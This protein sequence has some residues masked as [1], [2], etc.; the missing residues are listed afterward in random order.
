QLTCFLH[1]IPLITPPLETTGLSYDAGSRYAAFDW[2]NAPKRKGFQWTKPTAYP[3]DGAT[4]FAP[5]WA[6][7]EAPCP[8]P[9][10]PPAGGVGQPVTLTFPDRTAIKNAKITLKETGGADVE[11][12]MS[13]PE[14]PATEMFRDNMDSIV[15]IAKSPLKTGTQYQVKV[16]A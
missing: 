8:I 3:P 9:G 15:F 11:G 16:T 5:G 4:D 2:N 14:H 10:G 7:N 1:R 12:Y 13:D 6:G